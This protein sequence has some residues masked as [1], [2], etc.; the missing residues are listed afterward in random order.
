MKD[1][2]TLV[3]THRLST[4]K[5]FADMYVMHECE[6]VEHGTHAE[7]LARRILHKTRGN[8]VNEIIRSLKVKV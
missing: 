5:S 4:I 3:I 1:R 7:S 8:A 2:T 6:I